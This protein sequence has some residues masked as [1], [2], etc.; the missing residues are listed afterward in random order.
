MYETLD[1]IT[2]QDIETLIVLTQEQ[3]G[4]QQVILEQ[5][6]IQRASQEEQPNQQVM[7]DKQVAVDMKIVFKL[8]FLFLITSDPTLFTGTFDLP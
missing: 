6:A 7:Q 3:M 1:G 4:I 2:P 8:F 5:M